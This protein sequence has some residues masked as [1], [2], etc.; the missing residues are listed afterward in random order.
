ML[1]HNTGDAL[2]VMLFSQNK[3]PGLITFACFAG[4][5]AAKF[6]SSHKHNVIFSTG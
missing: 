4:T 6:A 3:G 5:L 2:T 1:A